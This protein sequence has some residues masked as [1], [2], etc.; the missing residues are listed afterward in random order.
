[1]ERLH[2]S[3]ED[4]PVKCGDPV[5]AFTARVYMMLPLSSS[6]TRLPPTIAHQYI[7]LLAKSLREIQRRSSSLQTRTKP[8]HHFPRTDPSSN[9]K[10]VNYLLP[11][12]SAL[13]GVVLA[14]EAPTA[15]SNYEFTVDPHNLEL[16][17]WDKEAE[18]S[19]LTLERFLDH[20]P[21]KLGKE[22]A[23]PA[24]FSKYRHYFC[25][26]MPLVLGEGQPLIWVPAHIHVCWGVVEG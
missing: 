7:E 5:K 21:A 22:S 9:M 24:D 3:A 4:P 20:A 2:T 23:K 14:Q 8:K 19:K 1:V 10:L 18:G 15:W 25:R 13:I 11:A 6:D 17:Q 26:D 16:F 12:F